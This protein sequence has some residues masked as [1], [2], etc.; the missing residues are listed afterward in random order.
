LGVL[1]L[2]AAV[3]LVWADVFPISS[4]A[5]LSIPKGT[6]A[7][8]KAGQSS[9]VIPPT[10]QLRVGD[11]FILRNED[12]AAHRVGGFYVRPGETLSYRFSQAG[13]FDYICT[14][15]RDGHTTFQ[16]EPRPSLAAL[17][18]TEIILLGILVSVSGIL[19]DVRSSRLGISALATGSAIA[20]LGL[21]L[22]IN[23][24]FL[25]S[26][27]KPVLENRPSPDINS[28]EVGQRL[29]LRLCEVC[30]GT[31][32]QGDGPVASILTPQPANL[33]VHVPHHSDRVL[34]RYI[35][36]GIPGTRMLPLRETLTGEEIWHLVNYIQTMAAPRQSPA[37]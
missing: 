28:L 29:Y 37:R 6:D 2:V 10:I 31:S 7:S 4:R 30:H 20:M 21:F 35:Y 14:I 18:W 17:W 15:H 26:K 27:E 3:W 11:V 34:F 5:V 23:P 8:L 9:K 1:G 22:I 24:S 36:D 25:R 32:G 12:I 19:L 33:T 16:V 13:S